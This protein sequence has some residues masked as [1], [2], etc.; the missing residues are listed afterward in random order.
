[1]ADER[2]RILVVK[3]H[4]HDFTH[5]AGTLGAHTALGDTVTVV[6]TTS[7]AATHNEKLQAEL[8]KP[9]AE[10]DPEIMNEAPDAYAAQK[11]DELREAAALFGITD[12]RIL[13]GRQP[14]LAHENPEVAEQIAE[15]ILEVRPHVLIGQSPYLERGVNGLSLGY[16]GDDHLQTAFAVQEAQRLAITP[17]PGTEYPAHRIAATF[18]PGV[19]FNR[20]DWDFAVDVTDWFQQRVDAEKLFK[21]Q[22]HWDAWSEKRMEITLGNAGWFSGTTYAEGFVRAKIELVPSI[23][24]SPFTLRDAT[25]PPQVHMDRLVGSPKPV[26]E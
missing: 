12:L 13:N 17:G 1:M 3:A 5:I 4:P 9:K 22:G 10:R 6:V 18:Y 21:S 23:T 26:E 7:G 8:R 20:D 24:L 14:F 19:Y 25:E 15:V 11:A 16:E 2:F